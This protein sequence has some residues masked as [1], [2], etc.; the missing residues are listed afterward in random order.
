MKIEKNNKDYLKFT[1][2]Q[3][4][5]IYIYLLI[6][7]IAYMHFKIYLLLFAA[8]EEKKP[9]IIEAMKFGM[10]EMEKIFNF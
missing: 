10:L 4:K 8:A 9:D 5:I 6:K 7:K 3:C 1:A 2:Y